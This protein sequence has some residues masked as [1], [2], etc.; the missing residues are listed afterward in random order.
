M[1]ERFFRREFLLGCLVGMETVTA[2]VSVALLLKQTNALQPENPNKN[3]Y[4]NDSITGAPPAR[5]VTVVA[6]PPTLPDS[7]FAT[8]TAVAQLKDS[9]FI[10]E[11]EFT[12]E[13]FDRVRRGTFILQSEHNGNISQSTAWLVSADKN[14]LYLATVAH[15]FYQNDKP[16]GSERITLY[17]PGI[18]TDKYRF[19]SYKGQMYKDPDN[20][21]VKVI[22]NYKSKIPLEVLKFDDDYTIKQEER[23][24]MVGFPWEFAIPGSDGNY[25]TLGQV[26]SAKWLRRSQK[27]LNLWYSFALSDNG[28]SGS[29][30]VRVDEN[31]NPIVIAMVNS[32][33]YVE[34]NG[35][36]G[37]RVKQHAT[38]F[39]PLYLSSLKEDIDRN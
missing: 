16:M 37:S 9:S 30:I 2:G 34:T 24:L 25:I 31:Q 15:T 36:G 6:T 33:T 21:L 20:A 4:G 27:N 26:L 12:A 1:S 3:I 38:V 23:L 22:G 14:E 10:P 39:G 32:K 17:R 29:P 7:L 13:V 11:G 19:T 35:V 5:M 28:S 8:A 18:D